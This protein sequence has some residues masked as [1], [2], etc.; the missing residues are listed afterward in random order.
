[1]RAMRIVIQLPEGRDHRPW[2][3]ALTR[4]FP[5]AAIRRW[6]PGDEAPA[7]FA[8][9][10][11][12]PAAFF[13]KPRGLRAVFALGAGVDALLAVVPAAVPLVRLDDAGMSAQMAEYVAR[14][15]FRLFP[16]PALT[17]DRAADV[18]AYEA[19]DAARP[20]VGVLGL[21]ALGAPVATALGM[22]GFAVRGWSRTPKALSGV[23]C[24]HGPAGLEAMLAPARVLV[25]LLP[26]TPETAGILN[27][28]LFKKLP[29]GAYLVN[30]AR[31]AHLVEADLLSALDSGRLSGATLDVFRVEPLPAGDPL[32]RHPRIRVTPHIAARTLVAPAAAQIALKIRALG[33]GAGVSA[34]PGFV[35]RA[36]GY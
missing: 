31:G 7:D 27:A 12:T 33:D 36:R 32:A 21:G 11:R 28:A 25:N 18:A 16:A 5:A 29:I 9:V 2:A 24:H 34:L 13:E 8:L 3:E 22:L 23:V 30:V 17:G 14:E 15:L 1:M 26:L 19:S 35:D 6:V 10:W 20:V 4:V